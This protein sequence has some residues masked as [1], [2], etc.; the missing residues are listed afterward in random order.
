MLDMQFQ[1]AIQATED[2]IRDMQLRKGLLETS[3]KRIFR[4]GRERQETRSAG[5]R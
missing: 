3:G 5:R 4:I 1:F 2:R